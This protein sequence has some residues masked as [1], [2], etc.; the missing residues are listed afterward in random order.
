MNIICVL[1]EA[2]AALVTAAEHGTDP[3]GRNGFKCDNCN[4]AEYEEKRKFNRCAK[5]KSVRYCSKECQTTHWK[6][7][8]HNKECKRIQAVNA[9]K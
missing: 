5:C 4:K 1:E 3:T 2:E 7:G 9:K 8:G 6:K